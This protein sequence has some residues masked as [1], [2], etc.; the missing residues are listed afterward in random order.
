MYFHA[1]RETLSRL[2]ALLTFDLRD[3]RWFVANVEKYV[4][5][6]EFRGGGKGVRG[7]ELL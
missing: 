6:Q 4:I 5:S 7:F 2:K 1:M 3:F